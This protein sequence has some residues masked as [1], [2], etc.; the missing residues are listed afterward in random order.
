MEFEVL[1]L[2]KYEEGQTF[3]TEV[4]RQHFSPA[5]EVECKEGARAASAHV[6]GLG[7]DVLS[8]RGTGRPT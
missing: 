1:S 4:L 2:P 7:P 5:G 3:P 6:N 8:P